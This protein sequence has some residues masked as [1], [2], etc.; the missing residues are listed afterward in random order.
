MLFRSNADKFYDINDIGAAIASGSYRHDGMI[1]IPCSMKTLAGIASGYSDNLLLRAADVTIKE[2]RRLVLA[3]RESPL[4][5]IHLD[6]M[7]KLSLIPGVIIAPVILGYYHKPKTL[8]DIEEQ[9]AGKYLDLLGIDVKGYKRWNG[10][11]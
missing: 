7:A 3:V 11:D 5:R 10:G 9:L 4:S 8:L 2:Q 6:N 1:V